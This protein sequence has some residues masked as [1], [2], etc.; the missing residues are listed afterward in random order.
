MVDELHGIEDRRSVI[1]NL[2]ICGIVR[3]NLDL[4]S[5]WP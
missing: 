5:L 1:V 4:A 2:G 3:V